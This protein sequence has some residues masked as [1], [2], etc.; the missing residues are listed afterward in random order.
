MMRLPSEL[1][2]A[3]VA[4]LVICRGPDDLALAILAVRTCSSCVE[5]SIGMAELLV[6][7]NSELHHL[8]CAGNRLV[9]RICELEPH[10]V[11]T[12]RQSDEHHCFTAGVDGRPRLVVEVVV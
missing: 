4:S 11:R 2:S 8:R 9:R 3:T 12:G 7:G 5:T 6:L 1:I 10:F